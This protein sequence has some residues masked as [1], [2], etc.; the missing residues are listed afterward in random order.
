MKE[1]E[2]EEVVEAGMELGGGDGTVSYDGISD[3]T[4]GCGLQR[5]LL[6]MPPSATLRVG[7]AMS[8]GE[9]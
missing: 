9:G 4:F 3:I 5:D 8:E 2:E 7:V 6:V 1:R